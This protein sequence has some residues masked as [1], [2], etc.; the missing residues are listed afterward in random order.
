MQRSL[1]GELL[2]PQTKDTRVCTKCGEE[3]DLLDF[4]VPYYKKDNIPGRSHSCKSCIK[5]QTRLLKVL[6]EIHPKPADMRCAC[7]GEKKDML[8]LDHDHT[9]DEFR[10]YLCVN[11]NHGL[12][13]FNDSTTKLKKAIDYL[14]G[15]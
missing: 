4:H 15:R 2:K 7:C 13:K 5:H 9:T 11:C 3:K 6:K 10:G 1:F 8:H 14:N 12:G